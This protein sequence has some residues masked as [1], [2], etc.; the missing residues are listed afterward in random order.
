MKKKSKRLSLHRETL[1]SLNEQGLRGVA[2]GQTLDYAG[3][4]TSCRCRDDIGTFSA[5]CTI[6]CPTT[7]NP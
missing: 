5:D 3:C 2:G 7:S 6:E 4:G 1:R